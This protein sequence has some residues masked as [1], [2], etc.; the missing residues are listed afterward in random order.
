MLNIIEVCVSCHCKTI[1]SLYSAG[2]FYWREEEV[3]VYGVS[4][5]LSNSMHTTRFG[6]IFFNQAQMNL[7]E[8]GYPV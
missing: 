8:F 3:G 7:A 5:S 4:H 2:Q 1:V 6:I